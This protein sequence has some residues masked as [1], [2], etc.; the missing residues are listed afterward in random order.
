MSVALGDLS[1]PDN[2]VRLWARCHERYHGLDEVP[3]VN[4]ETLF[5]WLRERRDAGIVRW[6]DPHATKKAT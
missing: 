6:W 5:A 3:V 1:D 2:L 4:D